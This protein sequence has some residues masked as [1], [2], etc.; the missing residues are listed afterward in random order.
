MDQP[1]TATTTERRRWFALA[2]VTAAVVVVALDTTILNVAIPTIRGD[3]HTD[4]AAMQWVISGYSLTL[5]SLLIV[6][7][8]L[9]DLYGTRRTFIAGALIFAAGSFLASAATTVWMLVLG[10][11]V[12]EGV[13]AALLMPAS[14]ATVSLLFADRDRAK[15]FAVWGGAAG[16][17]AALGPVLG[18][19][20]TTDY[21]WRWGFRINLVVAPLAALAALAVLPGVARRDRRPPLDASGAVTAAIGLFLLVFA[22]TE[23][24]TY[25][26]LTAQYSFTVAGVTLWPA[27]APVSPVPFAFA[28]AAIALA[29]F[30]AIEHRKQHAGGSPCSSS[31]SS[32]VAASGSA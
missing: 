15:A 11:A 8:R 32:G 17:S 6:G 28:A 19:W 27:S 26:W 24:A 18:G 10:E 16:A 25:G 30:A 31:N 12:I 4:L 21:S 2:T 23:G 1:T 9:G 29:A 5:G 7:G 13:G 20:L 14:L 22:I 3:L